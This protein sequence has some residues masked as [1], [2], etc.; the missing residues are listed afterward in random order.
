MPM[1]YVRPREGGRVRMPER[2][3]RPM[4]PKGEWVPEIDFYN[5]LLL[6]GDLVRA[7]QPSPLVEEAPPASP[8]DDATS[9][10]VKPT[11]LPKEN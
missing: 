8:P 3:F 10:A 1:I 2:G 7:D 9:A 5:R 6:T 11:R 4:S